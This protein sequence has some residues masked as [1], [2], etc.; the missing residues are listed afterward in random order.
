LQGS[1]PGKGKQQLEVAFRPYQQQPKK[2]LL[3]ARGSGSSWGVSWSLRVICQQR[4]QP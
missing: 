2:L 3:S 1:A 4:K